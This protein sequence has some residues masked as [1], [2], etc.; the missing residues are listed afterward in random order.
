MTVS[1]PQHHPQQPTQLVELIREPLSLGDLNDLCDA[2]ELAIENGGGFGW[3]DVP[4]RN[5]LELYWQGVITVPSRL[6]FVARQDDVICGSAQLVFPPK[7]NQA[8]AMSA[9][10][11]SL[12]LAPWARKTGLASR[13][14]KYI[15]TIA[16]S[17]GVDIINIDVRATQESAIQLYEGAGYQRIGTHPRYAK[18]D[19]EYVSG[20]Y[21]YKDLNDQP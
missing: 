18:I 7:N 3:V 2:T 20:H 11:Y 13:L 9:H 10:I 21:Y 19:N 12:F 5:S 16:H 6:L 8:Q 14:L 4:D 17:D 15:E 1:T